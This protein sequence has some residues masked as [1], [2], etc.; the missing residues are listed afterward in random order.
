[1]ALVFESLNETRRK[2]K[3]KNAIIFLLCTL[4]WMSHGTMSFKNL[5][6]DEILKVEAFN[7]LPW[8][9]NDLEN[10]LQNSS[11]PLIPIIHYP[12]VGFNPC[13]E[14]S[15][16]PGALD[17]MVNEW[18]A[19]YDD[20]FDLA[21]RTTNRTNDEIKT[22]HWIALLDKKWIYKHCGNT[23]VDYKYGAYA[24]LAMQNLGASG[25]ILLLK[26]L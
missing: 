11:L 8:P 17:S 5:E 4:P 21:K 18:Y 15:V 2:I 14:S 3:M 25:A 13:N 7:G 26:V 16:T 9:S 23:P 19:E 12:S 6:S 22:G 20:E 10:L 24:A 1:M